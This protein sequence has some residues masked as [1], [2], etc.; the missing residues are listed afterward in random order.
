MWRAKLGLGVVA[1]LLGVSCGR[2]SLDATF[3]NEAG[4]GGRPNGG[5]ASVGG[6]GGSNASAGRGGTGMVVST[7]GRFATGGQAFGGSFGT[8]GMSEGGF[9]IGGEPPLLDCQLAVGDCRLPTQPECA[10]HE[11]CEGNLLQHQEVG[12]REVTVTDIALSTSGRIAIAGS[13]NG[14][15]DFGG[16]SKPLIGQDPED[17]DETDAFVASFDADGQA[18]WAYAY[19]GKG[20]QA[21]TGVRFTPNGDIAAQGSWTEGL[22][23]MPDENAPGAFVLR[24]DASGK[25][26]WKKLG[27]THKLHPGHVGVDNDGHIVVTGYYEFPL[28]FLGA[29]LARDGVAGYV[30]KLD[31]DGAPVWANDESPDGWLFANVSNVAVDDEDNIV[32]IGSGQRKDGALASYFRKLHADGSPLFTREFFATGGMRL[33]TVAIDRKMR[34]VLGA[35]F[36]GKLEN[37]GQ[38]FQSSAASGGDLWL[39]RYSS[40]GDLDWQTVYSSDGT[41]AVMRTVAVDPYDNIVLGGVAKR[42]K[43]GDV[44]LAP[45]VEKTSQAMFLLKLRP[46]STPA[47]VRSFEGGSSYQALA[48]SNRGSIWLAGTFVDRLWLGPDVVDSSGHR[49]GFLLELSP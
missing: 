44:T 2:S 19:A 18:E 36:T 35:D 31:E 34:V 16:K 26:L 21:A 33:P 39:A 41:N 30:I 13:F 46:D 5:A 6:F 23:G 49:H 48:V 28:D 7:G 25:A 43:V 29:H 15:L 17:S 4:R 12:T 40:Q 20:W 9:A 42:L 38:D 27:A 10:S 45:P 32:V 3:E 22:L 14:T 11:L 47:W 24:L 8:A 1:M 37:E